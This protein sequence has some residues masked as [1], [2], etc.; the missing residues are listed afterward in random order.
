VTGTVRFADVPR[1]RWANGLGETVELWRTP[2]AGPFDARLSIATIGSD[3]PFSSLPGVDR[4][5]LSLSPHPLTL[6][7]DGGRMVLEQFD[8]V[9]FTGEAA[10]RAVG[11]TTPGYD[12]NLMVRRG[13]G[14]PS[15]TVVSL[16]GDLEV[17]GVAVVLDGTVTGPDGPLAPF[18]A[19][20]AAP[21]PVSLT[22]RGRIAL[23]GGA[24]GA[25][26]E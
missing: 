22:G 14:T 17:H 8:T 24:A 12:L 2:A 26:I 16:D 13:R 6:D 20:V 15:L 10:V 25:A 3:A 5:L 18:D 9:A 11:V 1:S 4:V 23:A 21:G 19:V 7:V